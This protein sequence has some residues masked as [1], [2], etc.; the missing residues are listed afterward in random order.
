MKPETYWKICLSFLIAHWIFIFGLIIF[1]VIE[2]M[3][4]MWSSPIGLSIFAIPLVLAAVIFLFYKRNKIGLYSALVI[5]IV[6]LLIVATVAIAI[7]Q[8]ATS[9]PK[10]SQSEIFYSLL[11]F[12]LF[13]LLPAILELGSIYTAWKSKPVFEAAQIVVLK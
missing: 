8:T 11:M 1:I 6:F 9:A 13:F 12:S 3:S 7:M 4:E 2:L 5:N 10:P